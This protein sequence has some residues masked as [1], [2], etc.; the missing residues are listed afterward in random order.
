[1]AIVRNRTVIEDWILE[2]AQ[3]RKRESGEKFVHP[4]DHGIWINIKQ[5][6]SWHCTPVGDGITWPVIEGCDQYTLTVM[7]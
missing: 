4:Y 7:E 3:Y 1:M 2:K 5:V 6:V